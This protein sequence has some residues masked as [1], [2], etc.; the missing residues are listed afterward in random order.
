MRGGSSRD[1]TSCVGGEKITGKLTLCTALGCTGSLIASLFGGWDTGLM[2]LILLMAVD[3]ITGLMVAGVFHAS[4][5]TAGGGLESLVG[6][7]GLCKK[8]MVLVIVLVAQCVDQLIGTSVARD[9]VVIGYAINEVI[10]ITENAGLMG[11]PVPEK[12]SQ[13]IEVLQGKEDKQ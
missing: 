3:Y 10:S 1:T 11:V 6:W 13:V 4:K 7:K 12:L 2:L 5:K 8:G 9:A